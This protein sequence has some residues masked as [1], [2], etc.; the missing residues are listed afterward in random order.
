MKYNKKVKPET[1]YFET[2]KRKKRKEAL[3]CIIL[4]V[5]TSSIAISYEYTRYQKE[6]QTKQEN[7]AEKVIYTKLEIEFNDITTTKEQYNK[8]SELCN[9]YLKETDTDLTLAN[10]VE[11]TEDEIYTDKMEKQNDNIKQ[12][13][14]DKKFKEDYKIYF[15]DKIL[16]VYINKLGE[17]KVVAS[18]LN[19]TETTESENITSSNKTETTSNRV[20]TETVSMNNLDKIFN[21]AILE[22]TTNASKL[23]EKQYLTN[24]ANLFLKGELQTNGS[25]YFNSSEFDYVNSIIG[26]LNEDEIKLELKAVEAGKSDPDLDYKDT[27]LLQFDTK[28]NSKQYIKN[29]LITFIIKLDN[30]NKIYDT[31]LL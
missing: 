20:E 13:K 15:Q 21:T 10:T 27:I 23:T 8:M 22:K 1:N 31:Y 12:S 3:F 24:L 30:S 28:Q 19:E 7:I 17:V 26:K 5:I 16:A 11:I 14:Q 9:S 25:I 2:H 18:L 29:S 4:F 6:Q